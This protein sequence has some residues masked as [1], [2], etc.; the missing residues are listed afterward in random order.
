METIRVLPGEPVSETRGGPDL[1]IVED[2]NGSG[3]GLVHGEEERV[4][5]L[6]GIR[7]AIDEN[8][9]GALET[10]QGFT[11][12]RDIKRLDGTEPIPASRQRQHVGIIGG[13]FGDGVFKLFRPA[14][15]IGGIFDAGRSRGGSAERMSGAARPKL[16]GCASG[17]K[18]RDYFL[19]K[20]TALRRKNPGRNFIGRRCGAVVSRDE[21]FQ[22]GFEI[23]IGGSVVR[24]SD[25][26]SELLSPFRFAFAVSARF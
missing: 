21:A 4:L 8:Q 26:L 24:F 5:T 12:R 18:K 1:E 2:D 11:L 13:A 15:P 14:Q 3:R 20:A 19:E 23:G 10:E 6:R 7:R 17:G 25:N 16:E 9:S 22:L